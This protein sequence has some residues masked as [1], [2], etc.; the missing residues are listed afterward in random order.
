MT[1]HGSVYP[2]YKSTLRIV[3]GDSAMALILCR[4][5]DILVLP[6]RIPPSCLQSIRQ[7]V[8]PTSASSR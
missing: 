5:G 2:K 7:V 4:A 1:A 3:T 8:W 6:L